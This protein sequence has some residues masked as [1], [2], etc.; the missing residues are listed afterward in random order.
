[1]Y[2]MEDSHLKYIN[3]TSLWGNHITS[4]NTLYSM[5]AAF[6]TLK[7]VTLLFHCIQ[8]SPNYNALHAS[9]NI[10]LWVYKPMMWETLNP[11]LNKISSVNSVK[12]YPGVSLSHA[13]L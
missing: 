7:M 5:P 6:S 3:S 11:T 1:M 8:F 2:V 13:V 4:S 9:S 10:P 12:L